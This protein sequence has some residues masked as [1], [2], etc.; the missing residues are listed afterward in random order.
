MRVSVDS[1]VL[2]AGLVLAHPDHA[3]AA[4]WLRAVSEKTAVQGFA[5]VHALA[6]V[7]AVLTVLKVT[8]RISPEAARRAVSKI[9]AAFELVALTPDIY[10]TAIDRCVQKNLSSGTVYDALHVVSAEKVGVDA[11]ITFNDRDFTRL[12]EAQSPRIVVPPDPP[13]LT[14]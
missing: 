9:E 4:V 1:S 5:S 6:E 13:A 10:A 14:L 11:I 3:R 8:P 12:S 7:W 2:I